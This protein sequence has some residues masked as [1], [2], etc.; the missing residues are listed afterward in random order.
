MNYYFY[1]IDDDWSEVLFILRI[2]SRNFYVLEYLD[3]IGCESW[4][5]VFWCEFEYDVVDWVGVWSKVIE[6]RL[7]VGWWLGEDGKFFEKFV[8]LEVVEEVR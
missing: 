2:L 5:R 3:F 7:M 8:F 1:F 6:L 4:F